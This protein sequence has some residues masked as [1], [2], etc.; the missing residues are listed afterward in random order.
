MGNPE[1][2]ESD[3][4]LWKKAKCLRTRELTRPQVA[5]PGRAQILLSFMN[6]TIQFEKNRRK[7]ILK[8]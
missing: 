5:P 8:L 6:A 3:E 2:I 7:P 1:K 4:L